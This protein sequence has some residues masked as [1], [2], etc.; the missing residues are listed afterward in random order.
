MKIRQT[1]N[2]DAI[3]THDNRPTACIGV[4]RET[5]N[6]R[7]AIEAAVPEGAEVVHADATLGYAHVALPTGDLTAANEMTAEM[8]SNDAVAYAERTPVYEH[9]FANEAEDSPFTGVLK[10]IQPGLRAVS[11]ALRNAGIG[12]DADD[13]RA[14]EQ[15]APE[16][17]N[18]AEARAML[19]EDR[20]VAP[21][22]TVIDTGVDYLHPDLREQFGE[23]KGYD[24]GSDDDDPR[25]EVGLVTFHGSHVAGIAGATV[26]NDEGIAGIAGLPETQILSARIFGSGT[27]TIG[28]IVAD[29]IR[30]AA[31][32]GS[33]VLNMSIGGGEQSG[34]PSETVRRA[35]EY[36]TDNGTLCVAA[37]GNSGESPVQYPAKHPNVLGVT[38]TNSDGQVASFPNFGEDADITGP[39]VD[40]LSTVPPYKGI[41]P[42]GLYYAE[43]SG[44]SMSSPAVCGVALLGLYAAEGD[45]TPAD[46]RA[47]LRRTAEEIPNTPVERQ[48]AG[49]ARADRLVDDLS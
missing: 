17:V 11:D 3:V 31:D 44:T 5:D 30:F 35:T 18:A 26:G 27:R 47:A 9:S 32:N 19:P 48:G 38:A 42:I 6:C 22:F 2:D 16:Q 1:A 33:Q 10:A 43:K 28:P 15:Y 4:P 37:T 39:G 41:S 36:A 8:D 49:I 29:A 34:L 23:N 7:E 45:I 46:L 40:V 24:F 13:P 25:T 20:E 14:S 12:T 21:K